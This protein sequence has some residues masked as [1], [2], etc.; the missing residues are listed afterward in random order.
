MSEMQD[1]INRHIHAQ[2]QQAKSHDSLNQLIHQHATLL[3][4]LLNLKPEKSESLLLTFA[5]RYI[6]IIPPYL[7][8]FE[9]LAKESGIATYTTPFFN[10]IHSFYDDRHPV[11]DSVSGSHALLCRSYMAHRLL[12][13]LNDR[14]SIERQLALAPIEMGHTNLIVHTLIGDERA[15]L[16]DQTVLI[17]LELINMKMAIQAT[18]T[19][20]HTRVKAYVKQH[21]I[22][23]WGQCLNQWPQ[24]QEDLTRL[25]N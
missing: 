2:L 9:A 10:E 3:C 11:A 23:G 14:V 1:L 12:E 19:F 6:E 4:E 15:N 5:C 13:E 17:R 16:L 21:Q 20:A 8:A 18:E 24:L 7:E 25:L 22:E